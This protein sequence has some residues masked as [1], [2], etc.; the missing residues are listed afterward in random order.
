VEAEAAVAAE[1]PEVATLGGDAAPS[2]EAHLGAPAGI[3]PVEGAPVEVASHDVAPVEV[4]PVEVA[5]H[6][7]APVEVAP[8]DVAPVELAPVDVAPVD[9]ALVAVAQGEVALVA[10][11]PSAVAL[12]AVAPT[13]AVPVEVPSAEIAPVEALA[14][15]AAREAVG[16]AP[17]DAVGA[18]EHIGP[19]AVCELPVDVPVGVAVED[20]PA[21]AEHLPAVADG[22]EPANGS[23]PAQV[24][25]L[26]R[27]LDTILAARQ[28][29][30]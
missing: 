29:R 1:L 6:D 24:E 5:P 25:A 26:E 22:L 23:R 4:A 2:Q 28:R 9:A 21:V 12:V 7:V 3:L 13:D 16:A 14:F 8:I 17:T 19:A 11:A 30:G 27:W 10:V 15:D 20:P 18:V